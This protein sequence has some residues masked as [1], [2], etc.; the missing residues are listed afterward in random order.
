VFFAGVPIG[1]Q[2]SQQAFV[3]HS[4][5][6]SELV[7]YC[8]ALNVGRPMEA[9]I[10]AMINEKVGTNAIERVIYGDNAAA[11]SMAHGTGTSSWRTRHLRVRSSFLKEALDGTAPGGLWKLLHVR[12]TEQVV[13]RAVICQVRSRLGDEPRRTRRTKC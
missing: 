8:E 6:E 2:S 4:T 7:G 13:A 10:C 3:T 5:A 9:M 1:W 11:I 12:G